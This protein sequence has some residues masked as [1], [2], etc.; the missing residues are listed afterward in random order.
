MEETVNVCGGQVEEDLDDL[1]F[2][3]SYITKT[4]SKVNEFPINNSLNTRVSSLYFDKKANA[5]PESAL[6]IA[7][8]HISKACDKF[9]IETSEAI[10]LAAGRC[11]SY[12]ITNIYVETNEEPMVSKRIKVASTEQSKY[13]YALVKEAGDGKVNAQY[14]M[15]DASYVKTASDYFAK[16]CK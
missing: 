16:H 15:P 13:Y 2:A 3:L 11:P 7:A 1:D 12:I 6:D 14:A 9:G 10:K 4:A 8:L 5:F